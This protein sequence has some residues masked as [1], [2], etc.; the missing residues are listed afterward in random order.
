VKVPVLLT[1]IIGF[2]VIEERDPVSGVIHV[3]K[4]SVTPSEGIL[5][6]NPFIKIK[7]CV[8]SELCPMTFMYTYR[9]PL[10]L[11]V[12]E[13]DIEVGESEADKI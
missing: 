6:G 1:K 2:D 11:E 9:P 4:V 5:Q 3:I 10:K 7:F 12:I 13:R 8:G